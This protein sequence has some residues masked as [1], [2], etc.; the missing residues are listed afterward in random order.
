MLA[1]LGIRSAVGDADVTTFVTVYAAIDRVDFDVR[2][3]KPATTVRQRLCH[4]FGL[5]RDAT[6]LRIETTGAVIKPR[7]QP[8]GDLLPGADLRRFA[9][10][11]FV[12]ASP[13]DGVGVTLSP[14]DAFALRLDLKPVTF[15]AIGNDQNYREVIP[16]QHGVT[17]FR[18]RYSLRAHGRGYAPAEAFAFSRRVATPLLIAR[19]SVAKLPLAAPVELDG[20]RALATCLK[21]A[22]GDAGGGILLRLREV[23]GR[24]GACRVR[25]G[26]ARKVIQTDL[27]ERDG[28]ALDISGGAVTV[29]L[30]AN[31]F[32]ALRLLR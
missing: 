26:T 7:R 13:P 23:S 9:V 12:D 4:R 15:E 11:G 1:R 10:Q 24:A 32:A 25:V 5:L 18:F 14:I 29:D 22:D 17:D 8:E 27:L 6:V 20:A 16:D 3:H 19:A 31:G 30:P 28:K 21:P 2:I